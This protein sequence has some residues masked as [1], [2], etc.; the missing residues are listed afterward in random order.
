[1]FSSLNAK[2]PTSI[3]PDP[4][5][6]R[7]V[8]EISL[9]KKPLAMFI[10]VKQPKQVWVNNS[11]SPKPFMSKRSRSPEHP[12]II[13]NKQEVNSILPRGIEKNPPPINQ[14]NLRM[15]PTAYYKTFYGQQDFS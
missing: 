14:R 9:N 13:L 5:P 1:M 11:D 12:S 4:K 6:L 15:E 3:Q 10:Q 2:R 8:V 7:Q